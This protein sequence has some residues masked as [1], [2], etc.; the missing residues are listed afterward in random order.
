[1][2][3]RTKQYSLLMGNKMGSDGY[4]GKKRKERRKPEKER[5]ETGKEKEERKKKKEKEGEKK[6]LQIL[7]HFR[8]FGGSEVYY[9]YHPPPL[10][11]MPVLHFVTN[12]KN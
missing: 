6:G 4:I 12:G 2:F 8:E 9:L 1:M 11:L 5:K 7:E 10:P 3:L